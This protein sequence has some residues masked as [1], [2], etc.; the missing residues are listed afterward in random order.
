MHMMISP[1]R[2]SKY[3]LW[4]CFGNSEY[5]IFRRLDQHVTSPVHHH[6]LP[7]ISQPSVHIARA[8]K[9]PR[10][11]EP[12]FTGDERSIMALLIAIVA[13][14]CCHA[15]PVLLLLA[16]TKKTHSMLL[17]CTVLGVLPTPAGQPSVWTAETLASATASTTSLPPSLSS[18]SSVELGI[19]CRTL[20]QH[21][22]PSPP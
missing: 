2:Y 1:K 11:I 18:P 5:S 6:N 13:L 22:W 14:D 16:K 15:T 19:P 10:N 4:L 21:S 20:P 12:Q 17:N 9:G 7:E 8:S 3:G